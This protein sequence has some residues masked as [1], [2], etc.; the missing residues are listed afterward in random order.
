MK[1]ITSVSVHVRKGDGDKSKIV[2]L[3]P[4]PHDLDDAFAERL[5]ARDEAK[6]P[7]AAKEAA[8]A[9]ASSGPRVIKSPHVSPP[10]RKQA[11][12]GRLGGDPK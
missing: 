2:A 9:E 1:V 4:G 10:A 8:A 11:K 3:R 6:T 12:T 7:E 5:I